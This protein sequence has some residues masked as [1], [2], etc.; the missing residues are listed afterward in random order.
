M[1]QLQN[2]RKSRYQRV[3]P[4]KP[5]KITQRDLEI[6]RQVYRYR[7]L[8]SD[9]IAALLGGSK[10]GVSRRL[11]LLFHS[12]WLDRPRSQLLLPE[13]VDARCNHSMV[14][15]LG[16]LGAKFLS[17]ELDMPL[18]SINWTAKNKEL[19]SGIFMEHTLLVAEF[20]IMVQLACKK[21]DGVEFIDQEEIINKRAEPICNCDQHLGFRVDATLK[22]NQRKPFL[23]TVVPDGA[24]GLRFHG[25]EQGKKEVYFFLEADRA[26]MPI[27]RVSLL[28]S[29]FYKKMLGYYH[30]WKTGAYSKTFHF[31]HARV[32]TI[33]T[34]RQ[35]IDNMIEVGKMI[36]TRKTGLGMFL[37]A[38]QDILTLDEPEKV[39]A[40]AW[41]S[42]KGEKLSILD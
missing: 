41:T 20:M 4:A 3:T 7:F 34:S 40:P 1:S 14:Y 26:T 36:D 33:T 5:F 9:Q 24:F 16:M 6:V 13:R 25:K 10:Q 8:T 42:G 28:R 18:T 39:F 22:K 32:L 2:I 31:K 37:F 15:A 21:V 35:R 38:S 19:K 17:T 27:R 30:A 11:N 29:S 12:G 23:L